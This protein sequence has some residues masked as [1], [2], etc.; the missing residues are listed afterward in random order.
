VRGGL[1]E[2]TSAHLE[3]D[4]GSLGGRSS[5]DISLADGTLRA[6]RLTLHRSDGDVQIVTVGGKS[7]AKLPPSQRAGGPPWA[8][9]SAESTNPAI[10]RL[11]GGVDI[12]NAA[13]SLESISGYVSSA[14]S[15]SREGEEQL[16]GAP[17]TRYRL[18]VDPARL[19]GNAQ[20]QQMLQ[21]LGSRIPV[22]LWV[23]A[24]GRPVRL[25][26]DMSVSGQH[27]AIGIEISKFNAPVTITAPPAGQVGTG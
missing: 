21:L 11:A 1:A 12:A 8:V 13:A 25:A 6:S 15:V 20:L 19:K 7:Y 3:I 5:E 2:V 16:R 23:D 18:V 27:I 10:T 9:V 17:A 22:D 26:V 24:H 14:A 4:L